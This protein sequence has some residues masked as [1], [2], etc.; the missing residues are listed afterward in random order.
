MSGGISSILWSEGSEAA[1][2][3]S[4]DGSAVKDSLECLAGVAVSSQEGCIICLES[5]GVPAACS[6]LQA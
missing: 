1:G 3:P 5:A 4:M 2:D 6:A